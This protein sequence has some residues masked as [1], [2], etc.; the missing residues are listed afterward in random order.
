M[1]PIAWTSF[2]PIAAAARPM[3]QPGSLTARL[4]RSGTIT[5]DVL[6]SGW[7]AA[8]PDEAAA[9]GLARPGQRVFVREVCVRRNGQPAV[10]AR[11]ATTRAGI[12]GTWRGLR[13]LGRRPLATLL[14]T[15]PRIRRGPFEYARLPGADAWPARRSCFWRD[16]EPLVLLEAFVGLPW[17]AV[18]WLPRRRRWLADARHD[19]VQRTT[20]CQS[21]TV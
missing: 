8:R 6:S 9:L 7:Q 1:L 13:R 17:P 21:T 18:G 12:A 3:R 19:G 20:G 4:A 15:D 16:G 5:V 10:L 2:P 14:W 11:S